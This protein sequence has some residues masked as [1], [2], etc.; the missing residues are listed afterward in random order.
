MRGCSECYL[1]TWSLHPRVTS[2]WKYKKAQLLILN[3]TPNEDVQFYETDFYKEVIKRS[4]IN[5]D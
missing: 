4:G 3:A 2:G 1:N 5:P